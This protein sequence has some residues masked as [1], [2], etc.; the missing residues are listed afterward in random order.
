M[1]RAIVWATK[2]AIAM[3]MK[4]VLATDGDNT[5]DGFSREGGGCSTAAMMEM[6]QRTRLLALPLEREG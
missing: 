2:K 6:V 4:R 1:K 5:G 3:A